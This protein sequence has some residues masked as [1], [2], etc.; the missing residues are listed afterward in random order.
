MVRFVQEVLASVS[1]EK[2]LNDFD[3]G[4]KHQVTSRKS[5]K[6]ALS[7]GM[8]YG[9]SRTSARAG[10]VRLQ[11]VCFDEE[12]PV[13]GSAQCKWFHFCRLTCLGASV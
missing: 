3:E 9:G 1:L 11:Q 13:R 5:M 10:D 12:S 4:D 8:G 2:R 7:G 6:C